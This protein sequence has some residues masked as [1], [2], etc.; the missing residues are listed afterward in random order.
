MTPEEL[1]RLVEDQ[2]DII[3]LQSNSMINLVREL[4]KRDDRWAPARRRKGAIAEARAVEAYRLRIQ[5]KTHRE[6]QEALKPLYGGVAP[7]E[8][9]VKN[10]IEAG[11]LL[12]LT[13]NAQEHDG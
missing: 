13:G 10:R 1:Q 11:K 9:T 4:E 12:S 6:I 2:A 8:K 3:K 7:T 5:G